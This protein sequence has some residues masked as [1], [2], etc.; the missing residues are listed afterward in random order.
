MNPMMLQFL[1]PIL[2]RLLSSGKLD[3]LIPAS[4]LGP[5]KEV[6]SGQAAGPEQQVVAAIAALAEHTPADAARGQA[7]ADAVG[8]I[9][10]GMARLK[11]AMKGA[12]P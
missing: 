7:Y 10:A 1:L 6:L 8:Q 5:L 12:S 11:G 9:M 2:E 4:G 3:G